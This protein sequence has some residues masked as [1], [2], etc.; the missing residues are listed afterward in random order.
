MNSI[1]S[2][3]LELSVAELSAE[4]PTFVGRDVKEVTAD[5]DFLAVRRGV[6]NGE[7]PVSELTELVEEKRKWT[8]PEML[9]WWTNR[10]LE[11]GDVDALQ[12]A[13]YLEYEINCGR[14]Y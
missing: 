1:K 11:T 7:V 8:L 12:T 13:E 9:E 3:R 2:L 4:I 14:N 5:A 10:Y 6:R